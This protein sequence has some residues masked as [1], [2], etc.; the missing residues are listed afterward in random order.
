M[1]GRWGRIPAG[2]LADI[3][4]PAFAFAMSVVRIGC[5]LAGCCS[6]RPT[7][8]PWAIRFPAHSLPWAAEVHAGLLSID[9]S[10]SLPVHPLQIYFGLLSL[11]LGI[12]C[13]WFARRK[14]YE[15]QVFLVYVTAYGFGQFFLEFLRFGPL[16]HVQYMA[17]AIAL[18]SGSVLLWHTKSIRSAQNLL[19]QPTFRRTHN[20]KV[21]N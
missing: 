4:A 17:L 18:V 11:G 19:H 15:G 2:T 12:F 9:S 14:A 5:L 20:S 7:S 13:L 3:L 16:P 21:P 8:L 1:I 10:Q 6:G